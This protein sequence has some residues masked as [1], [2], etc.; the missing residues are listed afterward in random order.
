M[1]SVKA[2]SQGLS[3]LIPL[4]APP[5]ARGPRRSPLRS[6][7][8]GEMS[9]GGAAKTAHVTSARARRP[10]KPSTR[11]PSRN[12]RAAAPAP[13]GA[14]AT[15][16]ASMLDELASLGPS[17]VEEAAGIE[18]ML[19]DLDFL[20]DLP[21][22]DADGAGGAELPLEAFRKHIAGPPLWLRSRNP[23]HGRL[24]V[25]RAHGSPR[26]LGRIAARGDRGARRGAGGRLAARVPKA[27]ERRRGAD[28]H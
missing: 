13:A 16:A 2:L 25:A 8:G 18:G 27:D 20:E 3:G 1:M 11:N 21:A 15:A 12:R 7:G 17:G 5:S 26:A 14:A 19:G 9:D 6:D 24:C 22:P 28:R 4:G 23:P 10:A